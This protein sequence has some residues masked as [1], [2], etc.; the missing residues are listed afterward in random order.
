MI[1]QTLIDAEKSVDSWSSPYSSPGNTERVCLTHVS[2]DR[3]GGSIT[4][5][6]KHS[7]WDELQQP[8]TVTRQWMPVIDDNYELVELSHK[9]MRAY[10][11]TG[12]ILVSPRINCQCGEKL[13]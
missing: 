10:G 12:T 7:P 3:K 6:Y 11:Y 13:K 4:I 1:A 2:F 8:Q 5:Q 9:S